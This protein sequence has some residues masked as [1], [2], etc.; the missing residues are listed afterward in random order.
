MSSPSSPASSQTTYTVS[1][2]VP[3]LP[4][5]LWIN[6][7]RYLDFQ[8]LLNVAQ[9]APVWRRLAFSPTVA[10]NVTFAKETDERTLRN[11]RIERREKLPWDKKKEPKLSSDVRNLHCRNCIALPH[12][13]I[14]DVMGHCRN[15]QEL[16][17]VNCVVE[18]YDFFR[19]LCGIGVCIRKVEWTLYDERYYKCQ[20]SLDVGPIQRFNREVGPDICELYVELV[21]SD[22]SQAPRDCEKPLKQFFQTC[23]S[24]L[25]ELN[26]STS[27][28]SVGSDCC[29]LVASTLHRLRSLSLP[30]CGANLKY[31]LAWLARGC[32]QLECLDVRSVPTVDNAEPCKT[33]KRPLLFSAGCFAVLHRETRL[34]RL[35]ID[36][37][38]QLINFK[39][40]SECRV[41]ELRMSVDNAKCRDFSQCP[42][43][44]GRLLALNAR[45]RSLTLVARKAFID[46]CLAET[47]IQVQ[48][49]H[50]LCVLTTTRGGITS[51]MEFCEKLDSGLP[52]LDTAHVHYVGFWGEVEH[53]NVDA[54]EA[55][56]AL[57]GRYRVANRP[58]CDPV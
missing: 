44:L 35:S 49:L 19:Y 14:I 16:Y 33:C 23:L 29:H 26:L 51:T 2:F 43:E 9:A 10:R 21:R 32:K 34:R 31:S 48:S 47:F 12:G 40:L 53:P 50:H 18:P 41:V 54:S 52:E 55:A 22:A 8:S 36:E 38:A 58:R 4:D 46:S 28:F 45:L 30:P 13:A 5:E 56:L 39:F 20:N 24:Q 17:C 3:R 25:T 1:D 11:F 42:K 15:L 57:Y 27:H 37:T 6:I 7:F